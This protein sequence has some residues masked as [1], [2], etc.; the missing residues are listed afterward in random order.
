MVDYK[1][2]KKFKAV[3]IDKIEMLAIL[4]FIFAL[5][6]L[7]VNLNLISAYGLKTTVPFSAQ[8]LVPATSMFWL[9]F[10]FMS[11]C[12]FIVSIRSIYRRVKRERPDSFFAIF[13]IVGWGII[14][15]GGLMLFAGGDNLII[16]FFS[17]EI[18]RINY[19]HFGIFLE[20]LTIVYFAL[21]K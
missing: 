21:T 6:L 14:L 8:N 11:V 7:D 9:G 3:L 15:S 1:R 17:L 20:A 2:I 19:Y 4:L 13:G 10:I 18:P 5:F 12:L 16:P